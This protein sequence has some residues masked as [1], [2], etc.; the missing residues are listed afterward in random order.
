LCEKLGSVLAKFKE[1]EFC[2]R[3][4][5]IIGTRKCGGKVELQACGRKGKSSAHQAEEKQFDKG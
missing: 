3:Q 5:I 1:K 4:V 2:F